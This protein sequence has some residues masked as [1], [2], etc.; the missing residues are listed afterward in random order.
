M[1]DIGTPKLDSHITNLH[2]KLLIRGKVPEKRPFLNRIYANLHIK[3][4]HKTRAACIK[5][6]DL[7][8]L[9]GYP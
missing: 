3:R 1:R 7:E 9:L 2:I 4:L 5:M 8:C 6:S